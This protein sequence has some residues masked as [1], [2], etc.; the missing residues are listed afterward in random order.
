MVGADNTPYTGKG[1][2]I[3][4]IDS[5]VAVE[6][7]AFQGAVPVDA[8]NADALNKVAGKLLAGSGTL[9]AEDLRV[10]DKIPFAYDYAD[11]GTP[12]PRRRRHRP[13]SR[14]PRGRSRGS[15]QRRQDSRRGP[16]CP[17]SWP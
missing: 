15:Q 16:R 2:V 10:D 6:H 3:A 12:T 11:R 1:Q 13:G 7:E 9:T 8:L 17:R 14:H 5:G 4:V